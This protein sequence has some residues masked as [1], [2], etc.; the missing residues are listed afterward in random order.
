MQ[1]KIEAKLQELG[2]RQVSRLPPIGDPSADPAVQELFAGNIARGGDII[3]LHLTLAH[4][5]HIA[6]AS[7]TM[8]HT[9]RSGTKASRAVVELAIMRAGQIV[10][11][12]YE[13]N[14][15]L[16]MALAAGLTRAQI[17]ALP[18]WRTSDLFDPQQRAL[19][20]YVE[21]LTRRGEVEDA[22]YAEFAKFFSPTEIVELTAA[23]SV[24]YGTGL[25][26]KA[27][28]IRIETDGRRAS[29]T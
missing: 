11:C 15:H 4:A 10:G 16:P 23:A 28:R 1:E 22:I 2:S 19:L 13:L 8:A 24:Y 12:E 18:D 7:R 17:D 6:R 5:P 21:Q 14:Q 27:L 9:L 26:M 25:L 20:A 3:N 29:P